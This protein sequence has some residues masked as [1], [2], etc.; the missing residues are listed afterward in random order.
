MTATSP[1]SPGSKAERERGAIPK[2]SARLMSFGAGSAAS[3][4]AGLDIVL[5]RRHIR[6]EI[7]IGL[8]DMPRG[9]LAQALG[10]VEEEGGGI[11]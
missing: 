7:Q 10:A 8:K 3:G 1:A 6:G 5:R 9:Q 11:G 2:L 4:K